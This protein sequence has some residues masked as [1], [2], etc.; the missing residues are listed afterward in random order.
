MR[1]QE[2][3]YLFL[4]NFLDYR[5]AFL[6]KSIKLFAS[7]LDLVVVVIRESSPPLPD[8]ASRLLPFAR[9]LIPIHDGPLA[10]RCHRA[11]ICGL[12]PI[13]L[14]CGTRPHYIGSNRVSILKQFSKSLKFQKLIQPLV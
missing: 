14:S 8:F 3:V 6:Q 9:N 2:F 10:S 7:A 5:K 4:S 13:K 12:G 11:T 1:F